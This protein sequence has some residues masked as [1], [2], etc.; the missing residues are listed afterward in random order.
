[1]VTNIIYRINHE[2]IHKNLTELAKQQMTIF[3]LQQ[4][5]MTDCYP[6]VNIYKWQQHRKH[7]KYITISRCLQI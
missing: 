3:C 2:Y 5:T 6:T 7:N 1:M 4:L